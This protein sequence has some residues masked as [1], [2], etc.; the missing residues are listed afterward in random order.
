MPLTIYIGEYAEDKLYLAELTR[1]AVALAAGSGSDNDNIRSLGEG[2]TG[3][4]A[5]AVALYSAVRH[6]DSLSDAIISS[7][8]HDGDSDSTGAVCGSIIGA[9]YGY[10]QIREQNLLCPN[11]K[12]FEETLELSNLILTLADDLFSG[13]ERRLTDFTK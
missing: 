10:E 11:G 7:V 5:W 13:C 3:E 9:V 4:E 1:R 6:I 8:N 2:W 12:A